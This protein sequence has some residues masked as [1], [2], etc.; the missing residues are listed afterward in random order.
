MEKMEF[1][2]KGGRMGTELNV[3]GIAYAGMEARQPDSVK[4]CRLTSTKIR[5]PS[6]GREV[7]RTGTTSGCGR[8]STG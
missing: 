7:S 2:E 4:R 8:A 3:M 6:I 5:S 1:R